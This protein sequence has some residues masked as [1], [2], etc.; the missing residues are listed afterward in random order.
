MVRIAQSAAARHSKMSFVSSS[1]KK[2]SG[3]FIRK[4]YFFLKKNFFLIVALKV[5]VIFGIHA[6]IS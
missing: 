4:V 2:N 1:S 3:C 6:I 5:D